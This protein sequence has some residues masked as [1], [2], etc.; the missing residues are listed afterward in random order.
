VQQIQVV[1]VVEERMIQTQ[2]GKKVVR[3]VRE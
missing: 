1:V 3:A 2:A